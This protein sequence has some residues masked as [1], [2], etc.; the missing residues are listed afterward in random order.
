MATPMLDVYFPD[1]TSQSF[2]LNQERVVVGTGA[3]CQ[4]IIDRPEIEAEHLLISP[5]PDGCWVAVARGVSTPTSLDGE[6]FDRGMVAYGRALTIGSLRL[7]LSDGTKVRKAAAGDAKKDEKI[8]PVLLIAAAVIVPVA[9]YS[10]FSPTMNNAPSHMATEAPPLFDEPL[11][12]A[13]PTQDAAAVRQSAEEST[14]IAL[15]K[16]ERMPFRMQDGID[17]VIFY[18]QAASCFRAAGDT[19]SAEQATQ[20]ARA[21][22]RQGPTRETFEC[23]A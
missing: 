13:C 16:A 3:R 12:R 20:R 1:G 4:V 21:M 19:A 15:S 18:T 5:R 22:G 2:P 10:S 23:N 11:A 8:S 7:G 17:A 6:P 14:R 9:L